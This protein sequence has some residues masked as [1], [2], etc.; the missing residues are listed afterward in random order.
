MRTI[1]TMAIISIVWLVVMMSLMIKDDLN[2]NYVDAY[3]KA[4][5]VSFLSFLYSMAFSIVALVQS[6]K[7]KKSSILIPMDYSQELLK[8]HELKE[9]GILTESEFNEKKEQILYILKT[10]LRNSN[11]SGA[12]NKD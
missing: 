2:F 12:N 5:G 3:N 11:K 8:I 7:T 4:I 10:D 1:K 9:K 6:L